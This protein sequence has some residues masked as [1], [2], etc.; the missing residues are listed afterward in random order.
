[1]NRQTRELIFCLC[2]LGLVGR[3]GCRGLF[4]FLKKG[5][6]KRFLWVS[7]INVKKSTLLQRK[8]KRRV[9]MG[10]KREIGFFSSYKVHYDNFASFYQSFLHKNLFVQNPSSFLCASF[11]VFIILCKNICIYRQDMV[12]FFLKYALL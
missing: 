11:F 9:E 1:M 3:G 10:S 4:L 12:F 7:G 2:L 8:E 5:H 6:S